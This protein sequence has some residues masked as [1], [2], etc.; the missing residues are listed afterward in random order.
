MWLI[1]CLNPEFINKRN[2]KIEEINTTT[3]NTNIKYTDTTTI[4]TNIVD[5]VEIDLNDT[6]RIDND[7]IDAD[8]DNANEVIN[9][10]ISYTNIGLNIFGI[11]ITLYGFLFSLG[12]MGDS[13]KIL[14]GKTAGELFQNITNPISGLM[15]GILATVLVQSSSTSTSVVVG[16]V[17]AD[18]INV[19]TAIPIIMGANI[20]TSVTNSIVSIGQMGDV[21][22]R[23]RAFG[24][25]VVHDF[26]NIMCVLLFLPLE[27]ISHF[28]YYWSDFLTKHIKDYDG[29]T[30]KSPLKV[31][32]SP[33]I[34]LIVQVDKKKIK[35]ISQNEISSQEAGSLIKGGFMQG[36]NDGVAGSICLGAS[37]LL[38]CIFLYGLVTFLKNTLQG[39]GDKCINY[40]LRFSNTCYGG[41]LNILIGALLTISVQSSSVTTS[42]IT[43]L[44]G[45]GIVSL[46]QMYP[47]TL[48]ANIGT[49]CTG[50]L[51]AMVTGKINA[52]QIALCHLSFN[53]FG[54]LLFYPLEIVRNIPIEYAKF[55]G[56]IARK[57]KWFPLIH[58]IST[59]VICPLVFFGLSLLFEQGTIGLVFGIVICVFMFMSF[60]RIIYWYYLQEGK[61]FI[62]S[63]I[64][65]N[66]TEDN[67]N[68][69]N[70]TENDR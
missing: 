19:K 44:V 55:Y 36:M 5:M 1:D 23:E 2:V 34:K 45:L 37:L 24:G 4:H 48:G 38:L 57:Y 50:L 49:T 20:G 53:V 70:N 46:E 14:G 9:D 68:E 8:D 35:K 33:L 39:M 7:L 26:F 64:E 22:Q 10:E 66:T 63:K 21:I 62:L 27:C 11:L 12:L 3:C 58:I 30:F 6:N 18:I 31:I 51:F 56:R 54:V 67:T 16:M 52:L 41:Y 60:V 61:Q 25:A 65:D 15:I 29:G 42:A 32:V 13:F 28:I 40:S 43:P 69:D 59:F 47:I 17:G